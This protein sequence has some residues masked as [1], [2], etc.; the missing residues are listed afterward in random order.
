MDLRRYHLE[1]L[2]IA[3]SPGDPC[4][5]LPPISSGH[6]RILDVGCGAGQT[7]IASELCLEVMAVGIDSAPSAL[8]LGKELST[9]IH[10][11]CARGEA[12]P[13]SSDYFDLVISRVALP[14]MRIGAALA[15]MCRVARVGGTIWLTLHPFSKVA[16]T[17]VR[18]LSRLDLARAAYR[19]YVLANGMTAQVLNREFRC[20]FTGGRLE[21]FQTRRQITRCLTQLGC[22]DIEVEQNRFFVVTA[23][24]GAAT[25]WAH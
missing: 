17:F 10:F 9:T 15:E 11:V 5:I 2:R 8:S 25:P 12:L 7:L 20:P 19:V 24:K 18:D 14:Y 13:L 6:R 22:I 21:S 1:E 3:Q 16:M 23:T 4:R